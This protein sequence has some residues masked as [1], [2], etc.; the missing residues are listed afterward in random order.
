[1]QVAFV[2]PRLEEVSAPTVRLP[3]TSSVGELLEAVRAQLPPEAHA[4]APLRLMDIYQWKIWQVCVWG[5]GGA[6][7]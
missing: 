7:G 5:G 1:M 4:G 3:R 6:G 2:S